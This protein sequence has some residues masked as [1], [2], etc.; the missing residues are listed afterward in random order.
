MSNPDFPKEAKYISFLSNDVIAS[1]P[2]SP[3]QLLRRYRLRQLADNTQLITNRVENLVKSILPIVEESEPNN[4][5]DKDRI[6]KVANLTGICALR[7][8]IKADTAISGSMDRPT[9]PNND[10]NNGT[11]ISP[12]EFIDGWATIATDTIL[13][14]QQTIS[15][16]RREHNV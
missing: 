15:N 4:T 1:I 2:T 7:Q 6:Y 16:I 11:K 3:W 9:L 10:N 13:N 12:N 14:A 8:V 5:V